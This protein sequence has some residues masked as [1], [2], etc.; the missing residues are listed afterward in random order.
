[1]GGCGAAG[2]TWIDDPATFDGNPN[3]EQVC[4][5]I[6][7]SNSGGCSMMDY[8]QPDPSFDASN[9]GTFGGFDVPFAIGGIGPSIPTPAEAATKYCEDQGQKTRYLRGT[10]IPT[11]LSASFTVGPVNYNT[12]NEITPVIA[13]I[14]WP[15]WL[16][17][18]ASFDFSFNVPQ[19]SNP[20]WNIGL[21]KNLGMAV[22]MKNGNIQGF[23][24]SLGPSIGPPVSYS[25]GQVN[26]CG[27]LAG[28]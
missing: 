25:P 10:N 26:A 4:V 17:F 15:E 23:A 13:T 28:Q 12:K 18:G 5:N 9:S 22:Y 11:T 6:I 8:P 24:L 3:G 21:G 1:M 2:G 14:P 19:G 27:M 20:A 16:A 7:G